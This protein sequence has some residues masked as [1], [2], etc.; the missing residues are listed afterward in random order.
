VTELPHQ[1]FL[2]MVAEVAAAFVGFSLI[3]GILRP[4]EGAVRFL[5]LRDV[6]GISLIAIAG[7]LLPYLLFQFGVR[8]EPLWRASSGGL[9]LGWLIGM[10]YGIRKFTAVGSPPWKMTPTL[11]VFGSLINLGGTGSLLWSVLVGGSLSGPRYILALS[12][13]LAQAGLMFIW[14]AFQRPSDPPAV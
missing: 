3:V 13:L 14:A 8:G 2:F 1:E 9:S 12:L 7:S 11:F 5:F 4:A 6:A 10:A